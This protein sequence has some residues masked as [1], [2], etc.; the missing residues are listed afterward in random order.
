VGTQAPGH[1]FTAYLLWDG[2][3]HHL[4]DLTLADWEESA[5]QPVMNA[6]RDHLREHFRQRDEEKRR[7]QVL[8]WRA[9]KVYPYDFE[10]TSAAEGVERQVLDQVATTIAR[11]LPQ[12]QS[13]KRITLR[14]L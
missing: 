1:H 4:D 6:A 2:F 7:E 5:L 9:E 3:W 12:A 13:G 10:P 8:Q 14:L 11:R